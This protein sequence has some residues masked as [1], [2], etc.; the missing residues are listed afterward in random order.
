MI[1]I[2]I[3]FGGDRG[4]SWAF[5]FFG[6]ELLLPKYPSEIDECWAGRGLTQRPSARQTYADPIE[7]RGWR[8]QHVSIFPIN[9]SLVNF[10]SLCRII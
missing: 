7:L 10:S 8:F 1:A 6:G 9:I 3:Y 5:C 2:Y 4:G